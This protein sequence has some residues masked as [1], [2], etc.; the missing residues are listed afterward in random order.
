M[1]KQNKPRKCNSKRVRYKIKN[2]K[3]YNS[4]LKN[5]G[6]ITLWLSDE[7]IE[8][9]YY[10]GPTQ[11]GA[12]YQYSAACIEACCLVKK[13]YHLP[14]RQAEGFVQSILSLVHLSIEVPDYSQLWRRSKT[15]SIEDF[16]KRCEK[17]NLHIVMDSTGL[18][19]YG[20]GEWK[21]RQY[22]YGKHRTWRKIHLAVDPQT[23]FIHAM[24][25]TTNAVDDAAM[26]KPMLNKIKGKVK[27]LGADGAYDKLKVYNT[28]EQAKIKPIIPPQKNAR[29]QRHGN[30]KGKIKP[31]DAAIRYIRKQGRKKWK[32]A[33]H[34]HKRSIVENTMYRYKIIF[35]DKL[36]AKKL[37]NQMIEA[38][39]N[40]KIL[41]KF[42]TC[43]MPK[44]VKAA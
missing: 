33:H 44:T 18:K 20:E 38:A 32:Q 12:Q 23:R 14:W 42:T 5:R 8:S 25:L 11:K 34:Y 7:V 16:V 35:G 17:E 9:W 30:R 31:R 15:L 19:V 26:V 2:W 29:I 36:Q 4:S 22:G 39:L 13:V 41:N 40:C 1:K 28:L 10:R 24:E 27:K 21:V 43:G 3:A 37:E 6:S